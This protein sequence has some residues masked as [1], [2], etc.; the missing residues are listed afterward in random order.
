MG[1][2]KV[3]SLKENSFEPSTDF[4]WAL[5]PASSLYC[6]Q[7]PAWAV[8]TKKVKT[9]VEGRESASSPGANQ[10]VAGQRH[11]SVGRGKRQARKA[12]AFNPLFVA[13][14]PCRHT[15]PPVTASSPTQYR[16]GV[17]FGPQEDEMSK[18]LSCAL[19]RSR[20]LCVVHH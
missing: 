18:T 16:P 15:G 20:R 10:R 7:S 5:T 13:S 11:P 17:V 6:S 19:S 14:I 1:C 2:W 3:V 9:T 12:R 8:D 4:Q